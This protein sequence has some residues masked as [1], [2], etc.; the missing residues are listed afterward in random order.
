M[1]GMRETRRPLTVSGVVGEPRYAFLH[2][3]RPRAKTL[4]INATLS[5][6]LLIVIDPIP[7]RRYPGNDPVIIPSTHFT[8]DRRLS[9]RKSSVKI[10]SLA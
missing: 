8:F 2:E 4:Y 6:E 9:G 1:V 10:S 5:I 3:A 7:E